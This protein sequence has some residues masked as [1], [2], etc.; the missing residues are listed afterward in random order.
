MPA[1]ATKSFYTVSELR[2]RWG[3]SRATIYR[4]IDRG[5]LKRFHIG[6]SVRFK[7]EDV[8]EYEQRDGDS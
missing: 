6:G 5:R 4:E 1:T 7:A 3:V 8:A 2:E